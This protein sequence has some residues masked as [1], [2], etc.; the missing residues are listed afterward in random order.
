MYDRLLAGAA[1]AL[2]HAETFGGEA[3]ARELRQVV[4][5]DGKY[6]PS[7]VGEPTTDYVPDDSSEVPP[8]GGLPPSAAAREQAA[9]ADLA[10]VELRR[11]RVEEAIEL[12]A[13]NTRA[14]RWERDRIVEE[15][16]NAEHAD[17]TH[18][19]WA[20]G[21]DAAVAHIERM[22]LPEPKDALVVLSLPEGEALDAYVAGDAFDVKLIDS[23][24]DKI[25]AV[26]ASVPRVDDEEWT[27]P[28]AR[29][30]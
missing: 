9:R 28:G 3:A 17:N 5:P 7:R 11:A 8:M 18:D 29:D 24:Q 25:R 19:R 23:A 26:S 1:K 10:E 30:D 2:Q 12:S 6:V 21:W 22:E 20:K 15:L 4:T 27:S 13:L 16:R 14:R